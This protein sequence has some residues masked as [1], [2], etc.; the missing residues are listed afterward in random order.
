LVSSV[1]ATIYSHPLELILRL[2]FIPH[3][4]RKPISGP[5]RAKLAAKCASTFGADVLEAAHD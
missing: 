4:S 3:S 1:I 5:L 2:P